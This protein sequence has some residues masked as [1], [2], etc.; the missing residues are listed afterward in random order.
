MKNNILFAMAVS[1]SLL[2]SCQAGN[3]TPYPAQIH[4]TLEEFLAETTEESFHSSF[5]NK[6]ELE[7]ASASFAVSDDLYS[8]LK[9]IKVEKVK[10]DGRTYCQQRIRRSRQE[11]TQALFWQLGLSMDF[12]QLL[13]YYGEKDWIPPGAHDAYT[14]YSIDVEAGRELF[15]QEKAL[16]EEHYL[17]CFDQERYD[18]VS[19]TGFSDMVE[20][21]EGK[22]CVFHYSESTETSV[23]FSNKEANEDT[24]KE[25][26]SSLRSLDAKELSLYQYG[27]PEITGAE[28]YQYTSNAA[29]WIYKGK[30]R[31]HSL[32]FNKD[33]T[34]LVVES[35]PAYDESKSGKLEY[36]RYYQ[37]EQEDGIAL[38]EQIKTFAK[39]K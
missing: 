31:T 17:T 39:A 3:T 25:F 30:K 23:H 28:E 15:R 29:F 27:V 21:R 24:W 4:N 2:C 1:A 18:S 35:F 38:Q 10:G 14:Y 22:G 8:Y 37:I 19:L 13:L 33:N 16:V 9:E 7:A 11:G 32:G 34:V 5:D 26:L 12:S 20:Q 36:A 6:Y